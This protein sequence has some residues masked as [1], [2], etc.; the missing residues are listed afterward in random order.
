[1]PVLLTGVGGERERA[2]LGVPANRPP[3]AGVDDRAAELADALECR[4]QVGDGEVG[5][6]GGVAGARSTLV[7]SEAQAVGVSL[8]PGSGRGGPWR[9]GDPEDAV[10]EP[11]GA[12]GIVGRKLD[13]WCGHGR[14][15]AGARARFSSARV[16]A[17]RNRA[18]L[19]T[20][21]KGVGYPRNGGRQQSHPTTTPH[22]ARPPLLFAGSL[23]SPRYRGSLRGVPGGLSPSAAG[24]A[25]KSSRVISPR[26]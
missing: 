22:A 6:G 19:A 18:R 10:P 23:P 11:A 7:D 5:Q 26:A 14:S 17:V 25:R 3:I 4:G 21:L 13:Q 24:R 12:I 8:P 2:A 20:A 16:G 1:V 9:E 15:M